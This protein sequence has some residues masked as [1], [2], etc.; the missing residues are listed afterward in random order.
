MAIAR[1]VYAENDADWIDT[2]AERIEKMDKGT[3]RISYTDYADSSVN[4]SITTG[5]Y[6]EMGGAGF[7][8]TGDTAVGGTPATGLCYIAATEATTSATIAWTATAPAWRDDFQGY[9]ATVASNVRILGGC[10]YS[11]D[12]YADKFIY[13][14]H[15][16]MIRTAEIQDG[17]IG[18]SKLGDAVSYE[19]AQ[20][21]YCSPTLIP[22]QNT[23][24]WD[25]LGDYITADAS[26]T[27]FL[28]IGLTHGSIITAL[29]SHCQAIQEGTL[30]VE[31]HRSSN[32]DS[33]TDDILAANSHSSTGDLED[34]SIDNGTIDNSGYNYFIKLVRATH[35]NTAGIG[36]IRVT[37]TVTEPLP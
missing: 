21:R 4:M 24:D 29:H 2:A 32:T 11:T 19:N 23:G 20:T 34:T 3:N 36:G 10:T 30:A 5:S 28:A 31:L 15:D 12:N 22:F 17:A 14:S 7:H 6:F 18:A 35:T 37:Y 13:I 25:S 27:A 1:Y 33:V 26:G 8:A 9:Y 16:E